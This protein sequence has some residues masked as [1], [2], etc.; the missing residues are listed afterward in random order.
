MNNVIF[1][2]VLFVGSRLYN[3]V[4]DYVKNIRLDIKKRGIP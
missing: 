2:K 1:M 3:C 4:S